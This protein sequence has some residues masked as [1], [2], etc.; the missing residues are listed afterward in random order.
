MKKIKVPP[1]KV[2]NATKENYKVLRASQFIEA[3][4]V[5]NECP[6][7]ENS[8]GEI[9]HRHVSPEERFDLFIKPDVTFFDKHDKPILFIELVATHKIDN[10]KLFKIRSL[11]IDTVQ[12]LVPRESDIGIRKALLSTSNTKWVFNNEQEST[13]YDHI[14]SGV[15]STVLKTDE[16]ERDLSQRSETSK[17]RISEIKNFIRR[18][19]KEVGSE[20]FRNSVQKIREQIQRVEENTERE[21][22][23]IEKRIVKLSGEISTEF[24]DEGRRI[25]SAISDASME[26][27]R[28]DQLVDEAK[29]EYSDLERRYL[30]KRNKLEIEERKLG[31]RKDNYK[32]DCQP[33]IERIENELRECGAEQNTLEELERRI[34][35]DREDKTS[36]FE[37][38]RRRLKRETEDT[39][40]SIQRISEDLRGLPDQIEKSEV[41]LREDFERRRIELGERFEEL[42]ART[43]DAI[44]NENPGE[45]PELVKHFD[46]LLSGR[47][48]LDDEEDRSS[49]FKLLRKIK[50][51]IE[52]KSYKNWV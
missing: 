28:V 4:Y 24:R 2:F 23:E 32:P 44:E 48:I 15:N 49:E 12:V 21:R 10:Q 43:I 40:K 8:N 39:E 5:R 41:L 19:G 22:R 16:F 25:N 20:Q 17:C 52:R 36:Y 45:L 1:I 6:A 14:Q 46:S 34:S 37:S 18:I 42:R 38:E 13:K 31:E 50:E 47:R 35:R 7:F 9:E 27:G 33:E 30:I 26:S 29:K 51:S 3:A 11:G